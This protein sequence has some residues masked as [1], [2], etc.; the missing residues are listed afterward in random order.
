LPDLLAG[1]RDVLRGDAGAGPAAGS[2]GGSESIL[3]RAAALRFPKLSELAGR[4]KIDALTDHIVATAISRG[5]LD[6]LRLEAHTNLLG[7]RRRFNR[8][9]AGRSFRTHALA[10]DARRSADPQLADDLD[11][12]AWLIA[13]CTEQITRLN[14]DYDAASRAYTLLS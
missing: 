6:E 9:L 2:D 7:L 14:G 4:E 8:L 12:A 11:S 13:R 1:D 5:D 3:A 10:D